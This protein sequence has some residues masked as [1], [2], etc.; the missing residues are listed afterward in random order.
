[1]LRKSD[2]LTVTFPKCM[3]CRLSQLAY[4]THE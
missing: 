2:L 1:M 4:V 3:P